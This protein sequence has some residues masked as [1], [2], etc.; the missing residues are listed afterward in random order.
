MVI[1]LYIKDFIFDGKSASNYELV[2]CSFDSA[3]GKISLGVDVSLNTS[4]IIGTHVTHFHSGTYDENISFPLQLCRIDALS[5][6]PKEIDD[7]FLS[8]VMRWLY[9]DNRFCDLVLINDSGRTYYTKAQINVNRIEIGGITRGFDITV[10]TNSPFL[11]LKE[12]EIHQ[13]IAENNTY[14]NIKDA[15]DKEGYQVLDVVIQCEADGNFELTNLFDGKKTVINNCK[16][17]EFINIDG[18]NQILITSLEDHKIYDDFNFVFPKIYNTK[19]DNL[20][21]FIVNLPC[22]ITI[23]Y[24]PIILVGGVS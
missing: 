20:N 1:R 15:S 18:V 7:Y 3:D 11:K 13:N 23:K 16:K 21:T 4:K 19:Y 24:S 8:R 22:N 5:G 10:N 2:I 6:L 14:F 9:K 12:L 17:D